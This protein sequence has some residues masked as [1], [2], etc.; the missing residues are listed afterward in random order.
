MSL[1]IFYGSALVWG[2]ACALVAVVAGAALDGAMG[3]RRARW[4]AW[5]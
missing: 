1:T 5:W 3:P 4:S 2:F